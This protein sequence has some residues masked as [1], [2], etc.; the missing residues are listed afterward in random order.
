MLVERGER[1]RRLIT[2]GAT[3]LLRATLLLGATLL[4]IV[5]YLVKGKWTKRGLPADC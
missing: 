1:G 4:G 3:L 2:R 5:L